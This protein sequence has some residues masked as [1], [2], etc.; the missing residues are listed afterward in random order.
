MGVAVMSHIQGADETYAHQHVQVSVWT[1]M[2][3]TVTLIKPWQIP[4]Q[5][6]EHLGK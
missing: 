6:R 1:H 4:F 5:F 3:D 2:L